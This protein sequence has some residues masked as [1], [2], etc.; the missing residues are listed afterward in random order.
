MR[1]LA[2]AL[3]LACAVQPTAGAP[4]GVILHILIDDL[5]W[6]DV[7][8]TWWLVGYLALLALTVFLR[9]RA[10]SWRHIELVQTDGLPAH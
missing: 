3:A 6:G 2:A 8:A 10:G 9:F 5:G 1:R 4:P 7:G